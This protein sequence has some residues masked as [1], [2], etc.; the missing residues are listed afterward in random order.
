MKGRTVNCKF[1]PKFEG[2][3]R[4][5]IANLNSVTYVIESEDGQ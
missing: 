1:S 4:V 3:Y 5:V 2:P